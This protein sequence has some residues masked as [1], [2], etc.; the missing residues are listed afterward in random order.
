MTVEDFLENI[1]KQIEEKNRIL[2]DRRGV[3]AQLEQEIIF[4]YG[5]RSVLQNISR[6]PEP[7]AGALEETT[8]VE[9][10]A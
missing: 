9:E 4:L 6:E 10:N 2:E 1:E 8:N 5:Q 3:I 7:E